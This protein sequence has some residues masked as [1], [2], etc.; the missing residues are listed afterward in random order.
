MARASTNRKVEEAKNYC[1]GFRGGF[2]LG[3]RE[4]LGTEIFQYVREIDVACVCSMLKEGDFGI[5]GPK[6]KLWE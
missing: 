2:P 1:T 5:R 6:L 3:R 4:G